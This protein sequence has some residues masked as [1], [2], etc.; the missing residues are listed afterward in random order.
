MGIK[1]GPAGLG[2]VKEAPL[3]MKRFSELGIRACEIAFTYGPYIK[4]E[5]T[6]EIKKTA[7]KYNIQLSI[8][9]PYWINLNSEDVRK[10]NMSKKR[11]LSSC[12]IG[13]LLGAKYVVFHPGYYGKKSKDESFENIKNSV[14]EIMKDLREKKWKI[15]LAAETM[16]KVN[17]FGSIQD[18]KNLV[19]ETGCEFCL[20][21]AH[22]V[23]RSNGKMEY[24][25]MVE[26]F[27][28]FP[29]WRCH[30]S[31]IVYGE[32]GEKH[33]IKTPAGELKSLLKLLKPISKN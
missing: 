21:F 31:G 9:A 3:N 27:S 19:K 24:R 7:E 20:D 25:E 4:E 16:G 26:E 22:L 2:S 8:H 13:E 14:I 1:F 12:K 11:I 10:L 23:A 17:V 6:S 30:F 32:K 33:H 15:K 18:I 5:E 28:E 29:V